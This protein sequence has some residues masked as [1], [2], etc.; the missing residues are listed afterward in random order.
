MSSIICLILI[1]SN[2]K[3]INFCP[4]MYT[5]IETSLVFSDLMNSHDKYVL[6]GLSKYCKVII[7]VFKQ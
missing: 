2:K 1:T 7:S 6:S 5:K 4:L 3:D